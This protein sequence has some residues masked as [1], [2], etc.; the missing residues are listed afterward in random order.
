MVIV[1]WSSLTLPSAARQTQTHNDGKM[2]GDRDGASQVAYKDLEK[3]DRI[4]GM[5]TLSDAAITTRI[6]QIILATDGLSMGARGVQVTTQSGRV[7]LRG[8]ASSEH[9]KKQLGDIAATVVA[10][11]HVDNQIEV[12]DFTSLSGMSG[13]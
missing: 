5:D 7:T 2:P 8:T 6:Q 11:D 3:A 13:E 10:A 9:E 12:R 4:I 1:V